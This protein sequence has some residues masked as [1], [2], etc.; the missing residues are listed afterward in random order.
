MFGINSVTAGRI[1]KYGVL[2][3]ASQYVARR[4]LN[5]YRQSQETKQRGM[6][7]DRVIDTASQDSFPASDPPAFNSTPVGPIS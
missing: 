6:R 2:A 5:R 1:L 3:Y 7:D 4:G